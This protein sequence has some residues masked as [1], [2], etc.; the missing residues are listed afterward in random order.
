MIIQRGPLLARLT[1]AAIGLS[2]K[3]ILEQS[4]SF[5]FKGQELITFNDEIMVR[6]QNP[7]GFDVVVGAKDLMELLAKLSDEQID[8]KVEG[9]ELLITSGQRDA[10]LTCTQEVHL[11]IN[12][13]QDVQGWSRIEEGCLPMLQQAARTC[14]K[15]ETQFL[16]TCVHITPDRIEASDNSRLF[17]VD[18]KTGF[19]K[20]VLIPAASITAI[21]G[22]EI[23]R[24]AVGDWTHFRTASGA[25]ISCRCSHNKYP[26]DTDTALKMRPGAE[27]ITLPGNLAEMIERAEVFLIG[28]YDAKVGVKIANDEMVITSRKENGWYREKK[29]VKYSG[30]PMMFDIHPQFLVEMLARTRDCLVDDRKIKIVSETIQ[31]V[32]SLKIKDDIERPKASPAPAK[33]PVREEDLTTQL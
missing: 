29:R 23:K 19:P 9:G 11:P 8:M 22:L 2:S 10:A 32:V 25:V 21:D 24:V 17:Q 14:G 28:G 3:E 31:F 20:E 5:V 12:A 30:K 18:I 6:T 4:N 27:A 7:L 26:K 1:E 13:V 16:S 15:D 33:K